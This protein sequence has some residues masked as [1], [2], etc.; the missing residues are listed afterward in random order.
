MLG[1]Q[2][3]DCGMQVHSGIEKTVRTQQKTPLLIKIML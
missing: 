3:E 1:C 2:Q